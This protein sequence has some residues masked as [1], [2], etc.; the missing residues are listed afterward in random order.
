M[1]GY[2]RGVRI[3]R[4]ARE[5]HVAHQSD[6]DRLS[7][8]HRDLEDIEFDAVFGKRAED[9]IFLAGGNPSGGHHDIAALRRFAESLRK[10]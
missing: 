7:R 10:G 4:Q 8:S 3:A 5:E 9:V 2:E 6:L 1:E